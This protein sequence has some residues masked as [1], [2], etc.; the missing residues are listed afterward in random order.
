MR[1]RPTRLALPQ[2]R[3]SRTPSA[4]PTPTPTVASLAGPDPPAPPPATCAAATPVVGLVADRLNALRRATLRVDLVGGCTAAA[5]RA[6][7][8]LM[9]SPGGDGTELRPWQKL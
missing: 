2:V 4:D 6:A 8:R 7:V 5:G 3:S 9:G 1:L